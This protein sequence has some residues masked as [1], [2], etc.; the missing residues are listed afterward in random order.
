MKNKKGFTLLEIV[1]VLI[2][3][4]IVALFSSFGLI[5]VVNKYVNTKQNTEYS[6][7]LNIAVSR[8]FLELKNLDSIISYT[9]NSIIYTR[10]TRRYTYALGLVGT[11]LK[12]NNTNE[13]P[14]EAKGYILLDRVKSFSLKPEKSD[15]SS[16]QT[17]DSISDLAQ[18]K[19]NIKLDTSPEIEITFSINP[20]FNDTYNGPR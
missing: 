19:V 15:G 10:D 20:W 6:L 8:I 9:T 14:S 12:L 2:I 13:Y 1:L 11:E 5:E 3:I 18:I 16:W 7:K 17:T 4:G